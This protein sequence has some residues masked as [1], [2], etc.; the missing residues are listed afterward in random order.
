M[1]LFSSVQPIFEIKDS[2][3]D[4]FFNS[5]SLKIYNIIIY[6]NFVALRAVYT[7]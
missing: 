1:P 7:M 4:M 3:Y 5:E 6:L 2:L